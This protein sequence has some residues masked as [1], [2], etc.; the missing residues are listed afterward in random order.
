VEGYIKLHRKLLDS[1][2]FDNPNLLKVFVWCLLKASHQD[3]D[4]VVGL[5]HI[6]LSP[7]QFIYGRVKAGEELHMNPSSVYKYIQFL[8]SA[9]NLNIKSNN[10]F[11]VVSVANWELYQSESEESNIKS[12]NKVT[13]KEQQSN[14]NKNVKKD[15]S[16][17]ISTAPKFEADSKP[18]QCASFLYNAISERRPGM[19]ASDKD[20]GKEKRLQS[21]AGDF[22]KTNRIDK[23]DWEL[24][25]QVLEFSQEN[26]FWQKNILSGDKFR[27]QFKTLYMKMDDKK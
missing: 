15:I 26:S 25:G 1:S 12:N 13:T 5:Q 11:S 17:D 14:T 2:T 8:K 7:G 6:L 4:Q 3:R 18:Y 22:E 20:L 23:Y 16:K 19:F 9:G 24:I 21:W 10:K 27:K